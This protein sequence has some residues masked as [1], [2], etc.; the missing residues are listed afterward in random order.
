MLPYRKFRLSCHLD[1]YVI[2]SASTC[3][4]LINNITFALSSLIYQLVIDCNNYLHLLGDLLSNHDQQD[5]IN[6][7]YILC[8]FKSTAT[9]II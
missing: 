2:R 5:Y 1:L 9:V 8:L 7:V 4:D 3:Y 6:Y